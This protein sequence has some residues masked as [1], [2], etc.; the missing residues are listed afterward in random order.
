[1]PAPEMG[2]ARTTTPGERC[3]LGRHTAV[4]P[5]RNEDSS[6]PEGLIVSAAC[7][8]LRFGIGEA[9]R[10]ERLTDK[11]ERCR[12]LSRSRSLRNR[13]VDRARSRTTS[14]LSGRNPK[15]CL[16]CHRLSRAATM[17]RH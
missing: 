12:S 7:G 10:R 16:S 15:R 8:L 14:R 11:P 17:R 9:E 5:R 4:M 6:F 1:M 2:G 13:L 3:R